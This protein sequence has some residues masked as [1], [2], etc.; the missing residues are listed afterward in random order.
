MDRVD[1]QQVLVKDILDW[2]QSGELN[3]SPW[4]QRRSTWTTPQ[5]SY[6]IN[7]LVEQKPV[8]ELYLRYSLDLDNGKTIREVVDG[9]QR[10]RAILEYHENTFPALHPEIGKKATFSQL[11]RSQKEKFLLTAV[12]VGYLLGATEPDVIDIFG[13]INS[14][15]KTLNP[16]ENRN[17]K[18]SGEFKQFCLAQASSRVNFWRNYNLFSAN[19]IA[20]MQEVQFVS[21]VS[22][23]MINGLSDFRPKALSDFYRKNEDEFPHKDD[24]SRRLDR[25]FDLLVD[26]NPSAL[27]D[28]IF[29]RQPLFFSLFVVLDSVVSLGHAKVEQ[30][31][32]EMDAR[33]NDK[34][35]QSQEDQEFGNASTSTTQR[36]RQRRIRDKYIRG[37]IG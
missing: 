28:T 20:R 18:Y 10:T 3:L 29:R 2:Y 24:L 22:M 25:V 34:D 36:I 13:R 12:P 1:Y 7:S 11:N 21:D 23:N 6:L 37:F 4:Y 5:K 27:K 26:I 32:F 17:A 16:Q 9:Q 14:V 30:S 15:S 33:A 19:D 8:P 31:L 35:H